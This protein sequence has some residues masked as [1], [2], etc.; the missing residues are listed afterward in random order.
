MKLSVVIPVYN[1]KST[2]FL[3]LSNGT[4]WFQSLTTKSLSTMGPSA[5]TIWGFCVMI[6]SFLILL[7]PQTDRKAAKCAA[8]CIGVGAFSFTAMPAFRG[9]NRPWHFFILEPLFLAGS[10]TA[11]IHV[12]SF[13]ADWS[14]KY[15]KAIG[16]ILGVVVLGG[17][18]ERCG[19]RNPNGARV[20][21]ST[22]C[23]S[24][25]FRD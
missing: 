10:V 6:A 14:G 13:I 7:I 23:L 2:I 24:G 8:A 3:S 9:L 12:L 4:A 25:L 18:G 22:V 17:G 16:P 19:Q 11:T 5:Y 21:G 20:S 1:G 15:R